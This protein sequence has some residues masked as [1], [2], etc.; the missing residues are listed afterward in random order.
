[1]NCCGSARPC[2]PRPPR[3]PRPGPLIVGLD[4][5]D[6]EGRLLQEAA[7]AAAAAAAAPGRPAAAAAARWA[8]MPAVCERKA[9]CAACCAACAACAAGWFSA[10]N[11]AMV[12]PWLRLAELRRGPPPTPPGP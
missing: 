12:A 3:P 9:A 11:C 2:R 1:V 10:M 5:T 7:A 8:G 4:E 6:D